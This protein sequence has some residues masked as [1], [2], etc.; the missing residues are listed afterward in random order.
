MERKDENVIVVKS[1][2]ELQSLNKK[3][4]KYP[5]QNIYRTWKEDFA[6]EDTGEIITM[7]RSELL[8]GKGEAI[9]SDDFTKLLFY[10]QCGE[11]EEIRMS[12]VQRLATMVSDGFGLWLVK[13]IGDKQKP[14]MLLRATSALTA[15]ECAKDFIELNYRGKFFISGIKTYGSCI[16]IEPSDEE[17]NDMKVYRT[18]YSVII[19]CDEEDK[20]NEI[21]TTGPYNFVVYAESVEAAKIVIERYV[22]AVR[23]ENKD[24]RKYTL[25]MTSATTIGANVI[26]PKEFCMAY[27]KEDDNV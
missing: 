7:N 1:T 15:Y 21:E 25:K 22:A 4:Y 26:V 24:E 6:D 12:N 18:W 20:H 17:L 9:T 14:K 5:A 3:E 27:R 23:S 16:I 8:F 10:L 11:V 13:A 2:E 19:M